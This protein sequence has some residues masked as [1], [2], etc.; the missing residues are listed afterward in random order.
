MLSS[1][2]GVTCGDGDARCYLLSEFAQLG[3]FLPTSVQSRDP[4]NKLLISWEYL[5]LLPPAYYS[6][7]YAR[8]DSE[9]KVYALSPRRS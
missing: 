9:P 1:L 5:K 8:K 2:R 6:I 3:K 7:V 4:N